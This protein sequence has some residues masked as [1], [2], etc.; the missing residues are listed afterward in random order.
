MFKGDRDARRRLDALVKKAQFNVLLTT[1]DYV[2]REKATLGRIRWKYMIIDEGHRM[3]NHNNKL[4]LILN[5][6]FH[7]QHR[8]VILLA[9]K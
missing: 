5:G 4:T 1:Y 3:K 7:A 8:F 6:F 2:L 9:L